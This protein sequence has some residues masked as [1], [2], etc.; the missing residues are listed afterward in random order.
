MNMT[1]KIKYEKIKTGQDLIDSG[2]V[3]KSSTTHLSLMTFKRLL[4][5]RDKNLSTLVDEMLGYWMPA[6]EYEKANLNEKLT[7]NDAIELGE[8]G[9]SINVQIKDTSTSYATK[10]SGIIRLNDKLAGKFAVE[11][12]ED[13]YGGYN[14]PELGGSNN[15]F[16]WV[17]GRD[18]VIDPSNSAEYISNISLINNVVADTKLGHA[19]RFNVDYTGI[20]YSSAGGVTSKILQIPRGTVGRLLES[21]R[22]KTGVVNFPAVSIGFNTPFSNTFD[23]KM[24]YEYYTFDIKSLKD[25]LTVSSLGQTIPKNK[26]ESLRNQVYENFLPKTILEPERLERL[27]ISW[28]M[29]KPVILFGPPSGGKTNTAKDIIDIAMQQAWIPVV[30]GCQVQCNPYS[31]FDDDFFKKVPPCPECMIKYDAQFSKTGFFNKPKPKDV[32]VK[33]AKYGE[34]FGIEKA[35]GNPDLRRMNFVGF[36]IPDLSPGASKTNKVYDPEGFL[37]GLLLRT[38]NGILHIE[39]IDKVLVPALS[40]LLSATNDKAL[41]PDELRFNYTANNYIIATANDNSVFPPELIDRIVLLAIRHSED[42]D[43]SNEIINRAYHENYVPL[44]DVEMP[45]THRIK[46][47]KLKDQFMMPK[48]IEHAV[49]AIYMKFRNNYSGQGKKEI[50]STVRC[51]IDALNASR[52]KLMLDQL[53]FENSPTIVNKYYAIKGIQ[54]AICSRVQE[55]TKEA[56]HAV[57]TEINKWINENFDAVLKEA[58]SVWW[59]RFYKH[60]GSASLRAPKFKSNYYDEVTSYEESLRNTNI[61]NILKSFEEVK[62]MYNN[63]KNKS[64]QSAKIDYPL[65]DWLFKMHNNAFGKLNEKQLLETM[66][67]FLD[68]RKSSDCKIE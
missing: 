41:K 17:Y 48:T 20:A 55:S 19:V 67:Y 58:E 4:A 39:E 44:N 35:D 15:R 21:Y 24:K 56:D 54:Y 62:E 36:K 11:F 45:D 68:S 22:T 34:G 42:K 30:D 6:F 61:K 8:P 5:L 13:I 23:E 66:V 33:I 53:F 29:G 2:Y 47:E 50:Q 18:A 27:L 12:P 7:G 26:E 59:C 52:A 43:V 25:T 31:L 51:N 65:M 49:N 14:I 3:P 38:N 10:K 63:P 1:E 16:L 32:A 37:A 57:K 46:W 40:N 28:L 64:L 60:V 9:M